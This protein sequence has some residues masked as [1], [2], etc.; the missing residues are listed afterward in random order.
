M[1]FVCAICH[2]C[3]IFASFHH[4][5]YMYKIIM[6]MH[7]FISSTLLIFL[8]A[9]QSNPPKITPYTGVQSFS[10]SHESASSKMHSQPLKQGGWASFYGEELRGNLMANGVA[11]DPD[12]LTAASWFFPF[13]TKVRV[14][15][16]ERSIIVTITD[17]G[18]ASELVQQG[19][20][21]DLSA[22]AFRQLA[23]PR[24]GLIRVSL[25]PLSSN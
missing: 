13:G 20:I 21:I 15:H 6:K 19:R 5:F 18:P 7:L 25:Y 14:V 17:R 16:K 8:S 9:C 3:V 22:A 12:K 11:F 2:L 24:L 23:D 4:K 1:R 10:Q